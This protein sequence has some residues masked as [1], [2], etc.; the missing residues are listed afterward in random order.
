MDRDANISSVTIDGK[1]PL[2]IAVGNDDEAIIQKLLAQNADPNLK[3]APGNTSLH[4]AVQIKRETR[5]E[6]VKAGAGYMGPFPKSY[7]TSSIQTVHA[8]IDHGADVNAVNHRGQT[9]LWFACND[10]QDNFVK[11]LIDSGADPRSVD[12][13]GHSCLHA[14]IDG[15]CNTGT[16]QNMIDHGAHINAMNNDEATPL[17]LA[18]SIAQAESVE[19]L[20]SLGADPNIADAVGDTSILSAVDGNCSENTMQNLIDKGRDIIPFYDKKLK[21]FFPVFFL[22]KMVLVLFKGKRTQNLI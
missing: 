1:T 3:D 5:S 6:H 13:Y 18:C 12:E 19:L 8:I 9:A 22:V 10:G 7:H 2:H 16:I 14:A 11:I 20:L 15:K 4:L 21:S 17:L